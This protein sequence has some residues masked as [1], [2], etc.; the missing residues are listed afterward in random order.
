MLGLVLGTGD[1]ERNKGKCGPQF[2]D[3]LVG[4]GRQAANTQIIRE[5]PGTPVVRTLMV[6][7]DGVDLIPHQ[8]TK[9]PQTSQCGQ[10]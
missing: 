5:F 6:T 8:G 7:A 1:P 3:I 9:I 10:K 4:R 2:A